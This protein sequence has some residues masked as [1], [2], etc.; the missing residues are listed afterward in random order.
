M[1][2]VDLDAGR[3]RET[4]RVQTAVEKIFDVQLLAAVCFP[5]VMGLRKDMIQHT[6]VVP[7]LV[8]SPRSDGLAFFAASCV[9][10][11]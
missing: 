11:A 2:V 6:F 1:A 5:E 9:G 7:P 8:R 10:I 4:L 3:V